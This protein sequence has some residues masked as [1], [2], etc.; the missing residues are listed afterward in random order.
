[1][2][3]L[4]ALCLLLEP[5][6]IKQFILPEGEQLGGGGGNGSWGP[7][8]R[9]EVSAGGGGMCRLKRIVPV[10]IS[11][12]CVFCISLTRMDRE[13]WAVKFGRSLSFAALC[14]IWVYLVGVWRRSGGAFNTFT[15]NLV[16][17]FCPVLFINTVCAALF[18]AACLAG[19]VFLYLDMH[20]QPTVHCTVPAAQPAYREVSPEPDA[21]GQIMTTIAEEESE[22]DLEAC[23]RMARQGRGGGFS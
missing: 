9:V 3:C 22:E 14:I 18:V 6:R 13:G 19:F 4:R 11:T 7:S 21:E 20:R 12:A 5:G 2:W 17:R 23:L 16:G 10:L 15:Q 8:V 1:V